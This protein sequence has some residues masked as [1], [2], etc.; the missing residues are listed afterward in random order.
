M[1][2]KI[3]ARTTP[4]GKESGSK[5]APLT[6]EVLENEINEWLDSNPN[7]DVKE[8]KQTQGAGNR[9]PTKVVVSIWYEDKL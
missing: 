1:R 7:I 3:F 9:E 5:S 2:V 4:K 6:S 8:I